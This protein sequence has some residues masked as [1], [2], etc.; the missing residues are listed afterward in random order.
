MSAPKQVIFCFLAAGFIEITNIKA[1]AQTDSAPDIQ[2]TSDPKTDNKTN[3]SK[4]PPPRIFGELRL[5][6]NGVDDDGFSNKAN[7]LTLRGVAGLE[8]SFLPKTSVLV[9]AEG[10]LALVDDFNDGSSQRLDVPFIP[11]ANGLELNRA[12]ILTEI[13][14]RTRLTLGRQRI[15]FDDGRFI[16][17]APFRQNNQTFDAVRGRVN[18]FKTG[19]V[20]VA[21]INRVNRILGADSPLGR[22]EGDSIAANINLQTP[23]G[24]LIGYH[25]ALDFT[26]RDTD[27]PNSTASNTT[28]GVMLS[29]R[30]HWDNKGL[31]WELGY[32]NQRDFA[33]NPNDYEVDYGLA[34]LRGEIGPWQLRGKAEI[35]GG[36]DVQGFQTPAASLRK[37]Q[38][39]A[40]VFLQTPPDGIE[41]ISI[42]ARYKLGNRGPFKDVRFSVQNH[43]FSA[44]RG[45][46]DYGTE[47]NATIQFH[48]KNIATR[49]DFASYNAENFANDTQKVFLTFTRSF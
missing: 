11:D 28:T 26:T 36:S 8:Y 16:G 9:E 22:F 49:L 32:A 48:L 42:Q 6:Y 3:E 46:T 18:L 1:F 12:Q 2:S 10:V 41:D 21:Y 24:R 35:L 31:V 7:E 13:I 44:A 29:G 45:N 4:N 47:I 20:D 15:V 23:L 17:D 19:F 27:T 38:G 33:D 14:P 43:W 40:D 39:L 30:R 37:F 25:Y 34:S 5:R